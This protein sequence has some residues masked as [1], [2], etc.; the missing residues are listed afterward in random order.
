MAP[1]P[2]K[3]TMARGLKAQRNPDESIL[4]YLTRAGLIHRGFRICKRN[5]G[6]EKWGILNPLLKETV[7]LPSKQICVA[8]INFWVD[9][10]MKLQAPPLNED[11]EYQYPE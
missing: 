11:G 9:G 2:Y 5:A 1:A 6:A 8:V 7:W 4:S 10:K 3:K